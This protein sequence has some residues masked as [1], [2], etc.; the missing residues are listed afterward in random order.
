MVCTFSHGVECG[1]LF[2]NQTHACKK[3]G[4]FSEILFPASS[5]KLLPAFRHSG[6]QTLSQETLLIKECPRMR[7]FDM[8]G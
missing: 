4:N 2:P 5:I 8:Q 1:A 6:C 3:A 7:R